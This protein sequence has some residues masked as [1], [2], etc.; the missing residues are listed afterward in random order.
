MEKKLRKVIAFCKGNSRQCST[1]SNVPYFFLKNLENKGV[2]VVRINTQLEDDNTI[3]KQVIKYANALIRH[4]YRLFQKDS[5]AMNTV[6]RCKFYEMIETHRIEDAIAK[7]GD[8]D[9]ALF[10]DY[11]HS[12]KENCN[13]KVVLFCDWTIEYEIEHHQ[14]R[15][16]NYWEQKAIKRQYEHMERADCIITLFPNVYTQLVKQFGS[17]KVFYLGNV[18]NAEI[19]KDIDVANTVELHRASNRILMIGRKAYKSGLVQLAKAVKIYNS[20]KSIQD[21]LYID[22]VGMTEKE[23]GLVDSHIIY[24]GYLNKNNPEQKKIYYNLIK[25][26]KLICNTTENWIGA[27]SI[28]EAMYWRLPVIINPT[29]DIYKTFGRD[30]KFGRYVCRNDAVEIHAALE[31]LFKL[32]RAAYEKLCEAAY[33]AVKD[34]TWEGYV[35]RVVKT[36]E[37]L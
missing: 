24:Y 30:I 28:I 10:F 31:W 12:L 20:G 14:N 1:W 8:A 33:K 23:T 34:F 25:N 15:T 21:E 13:L 17:N 37:S 3:A 35:E 26:A 18:I 11:S 19:N 2:E 22:V 6:D 27:S 36:I 9:V 5:T 4:T 32:D 7:N 16:P 29:E